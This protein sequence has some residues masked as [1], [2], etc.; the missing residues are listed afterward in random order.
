MESLSGITREELIE[1]LEFTS[2]YYDIQKK[3]YQLTDEYLSGDIRA[4]IEYLEQLAQN[5]LEQKEN[6]LRVIVAPWTE[7]P[8]Y[9]PKNDIES[10]LFTKSYP[11]M[12]DKIYFQ[13]HASEN[14]EF[15]LS[16]LGKFGS[17]SS[18][19]IPEQYKDD[20]LFALRAYKYGRTPNG[21]TEGEK[22]LKKIC[23]EIEP[24]KS[25]WGSLT[26]EDASLYNFLE[27]K[28]T[29]YN[30]GDRD[31]LKKDL[32]GEWEQYKATI[33]ERKENIVTQGTNEA[34]RNI[35]IQLNLIQKKSHN[36]R[37]CKTKRFKA[38]GNSD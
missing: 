14:I 6:A 9:E 18:L 8:T 13:E 21:I 1:Q 37:I 29:E 32:K 38:I 26:I 7:V 33:E 15:T 35:G 5:L 19:S 17:Y 30:N 20:P 27:K 28:F 3:E 34:V 24:N 25:L 31:I 4:K 12:N 11:S 23:K 36:L 10:N 16:V 2:I 22:L